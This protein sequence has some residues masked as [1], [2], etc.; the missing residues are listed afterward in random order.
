MELVA[1]IGPRM[2]FADRRHGDARRHGAA[3]P[4]APRR[5]HPPRPRRRRPRSS[6][7]RSAVGDR[8]GCDLL[9]LPHRGRLARHRPG[10]VG[11]VEGRPRPRAGPP[12][13]PRARGWPASTSD[14][15]EFP[16]DEH[17]EHARRRAAPWSTAA[18]HAL[19]VDRRRPAG[20]VQPGRRACWPCTASTCGPPTRRPRTAWRS[21]SSRSTSAVRLV[22]A[23]GPGHRDRR[24]GASRAGWPSR[25]ASARADRA[26]ADRRPAETCPRRR[27]ASTT[28]RPRPRRSSRSIAPRPHRPALPGDPGRSPS[29]TSTSAPPRSR[30]SAIR[31]STPST[32]DPHGRQARRPDPRRPRRELLLHAPIRR[33][34]GLTGASV[35][36]QAA[37][38]ASRRM[39]RPSLPLP[40]ESATCS[41]GARRS[42]GSPAPGSASPRACTSGSAS[43]RCSPSPPTSATRRRGASASSSRDL[44]D[45]WMKVVGEGVP[46]YVTPEGRGRRGRRQRPG[47]DPPRSSG[48]TRAS[49]C[50]RPAGP[51]S[52]TRRPRWR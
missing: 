34:L 21:S 12:H 51:T 5:R 16:I 7:S 49:G 40:H 6:S 41:G 4:A 13:R 36:R 37:R 11:H 15:V 17:R 22:I 47:R 24:R 28:T 39:D 38:V 42:R 46:G 27:V 30:R 32:R 50:T 52:A 23:V 45:E 48:P 43:R 20:P 25:P 2:G 14:R 8:G 33:A 35:D 10:R 9:A 31:S 1:T 29:S 19:T 3:P 26:Y 18:D 44:V